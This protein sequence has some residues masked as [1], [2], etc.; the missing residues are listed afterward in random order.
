MKTILLFISI[1]FAVNTFSQ[2]TLIPDPNFE[3]VLIIFGYDTGS[4]DGSV[5]TAN[6]SSVTSLTVTGS[7]I[8]DLTGI[9]D[10]T[11]LTVLWC[12]NNQLTFLDV[13]QNT[14]LIR[15]ECDQ[16][17]LTSLDVSQ[18]TFLTVLSC[19]S[20]QL[21]SLDVSQ[22]VALT[23]LYCN[24]NPFTSLDVSQNTALTKLWCYSNQ[25]TSLD[26]SQNTAL[27]ELRCEQNQLN[28]LNVKNG[29][30]SNFN[31][32]AVFENPDLTCITVDNIAYSTTNWIFIDPQTSFSTNCGNAC[33]LSISELN[34]NTPKKLSKIIDLTG[35]EIQYRKNTLMIY[36]YEDGSSERV[37]ELE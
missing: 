25:L 9:Q 4:P 18:N 15:L 27:I 33:S 21:T 35:R 6:I 10:F 1:T 31:Y 28:C 36:I 17:Q 24:S 20:N 13:T 7:G 26:V 34:T 19:Y 32:L 3:Q 23:N 14:Q 8:A 22:N 30:N 2:T 11:A 16:N 12:Y 5:P 29:N 37:V